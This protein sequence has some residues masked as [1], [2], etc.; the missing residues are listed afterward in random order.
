MAKAALWSDNHLELSAFLQGGSLVVHL[1]WVFNS[2]FL[3]CCQ[4]INNSSILLSTLLAVIFL[5]NHY[6]LLCS[7]EILML[8]GQR[9]LGS[10]AVDL[11]AINQQRQTKW[12]TQY[13][14][15]RSEVV[16]GF[17]G[18]I[19]LSSSITERCHQGTIALCHACLV[20]ASSTTY[21]KAVEKQALKSHHRGNSID[22]PWLKWLKHQPSDIV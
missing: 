13:S 12:L 20:Q 11:S 17:L 14:H 1:L 5:D 2:V 9:A 16:T 22:G 10:K 6:T 18:Q 19:F 3:L 15:V 7:C 8:T 21:H 4:L